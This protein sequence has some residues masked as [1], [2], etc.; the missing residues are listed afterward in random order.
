MF[1]A[2][3][4]QVKASVGPM[5]GA[6]RTEGVSC[7]RGSGTNFC[8]EIPRDKEGKSRADFGYEGFQVGVVGGMVFR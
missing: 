6:M 7:F 3:L 2:E 4:A 1:V 8:V 5:A